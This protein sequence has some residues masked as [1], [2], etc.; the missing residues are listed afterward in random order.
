MEFDNA[1]VAVL[2]GSQSGNS[3][4]VAEAIA[5]R[6]RHAGFETQVFPEE[7]PTDGQISDLEV[8]FVC[9]SSHG[10]GELPDNLRPVHERWMKEQ[11]DLSHLSYAVIC[12]GDSTYSETFCAAGATMDRDL[13]CLGAGRMCPRFEIDVSLDPFADDAALGWIDD[14][15]LR[16]RGESTRRY[17]AAV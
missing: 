5:D 8:L 17:R 9:T 7:G 3:A 2:Y 10:L 11:I 4:L 13:E 6:L 15:I 16:A 14:W 1:R 12:L